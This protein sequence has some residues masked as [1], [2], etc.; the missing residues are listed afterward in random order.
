MGDLPRRMPGGAA[1]QF[2]FFQQHDI[3]PTLMRE[4]I[5]KAAAHDAAADDNDPGVRWNHAARSF[6]QMF[7]IDRCK[8]Q[9]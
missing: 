8:R 5:G 4:V 9:M 3:A 6:K 7:P 1:R 2:G